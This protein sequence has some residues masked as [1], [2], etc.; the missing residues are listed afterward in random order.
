MRYERENKPKDAFE[1][2][3]LLDFLVL[4]VIQLFYVD[5]NLHPS[6]FKKLSLVSLTFNHFSRM[7][8]LS[9]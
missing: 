1:D 3:E 6:L 8:Q 4:S 2:P 7:K 9:S 5:D